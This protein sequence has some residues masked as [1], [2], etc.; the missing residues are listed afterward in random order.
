MLADQT[1]KIFEALLGYFRSAVQISSWPLVASQ[2]SLALE[3]ESSARRG[4]IR[5]RDDEVKIS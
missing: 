3:T 4:E 2:F 1:Y 5:P